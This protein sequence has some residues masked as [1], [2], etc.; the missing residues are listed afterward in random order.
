MIDVSTRVAV[1]VITR[2]TV[3]IMIDRV[4][5]GGEERGGIAL[6]HNLV[7]LRHL[8]TS[9]HHGGCRDDDFLN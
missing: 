5:M 4:V 8:L 2:I 7:V 1:V 3:P 9:K 6:G